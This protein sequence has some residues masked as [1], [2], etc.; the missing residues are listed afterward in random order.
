MSHGGV[1]EGRVDDVSADQDRIAIR[2]ESKPGKRLDSAEIDACLQHTVG[3]AGG[4]AHQP[5]LRRGGSWLREAGRE[6]GR[7]ATCTWSAAR[8]RHPRLERDR[9]RGIGR[10]ALQVHSVALISFALDSGIEIFAS[11]VVVW[12]LTGSERADREQLARRLIAAAF[13]AVAAYVLFE[14]IRSLANGTNAGTSTL[15][16][17]WVAATVV[18]MLGFAAAK[19]YGTPIGESGAG[20]EAKVTL[21]DAGLAAGV[22]VGLIA[23]AAL[24]WRWVD[25]AAGLLIAYYAIPEGWKTG[26]ALRVR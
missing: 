18:V 9:V 7:C 13:F 6:P 20:H 5:G 15:G 19:P 14:A 2:L 17:A 25:P 26:D 16:T 11:L 3:K 4:T 8:I 12:Q 24:G 10:T 21:I 22:L 23:N 1:P